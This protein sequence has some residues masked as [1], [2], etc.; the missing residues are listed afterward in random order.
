MIL[1]MKSVKEQ[2]GHNVRRYRDRIGLGQFELA[3]AVGMSQTAIGLL[4]RGKVWPE[5][6]NL[7]RIAEVCQVP[8]AAFFEVG[9]VEIKPTPEEALKVL[10]DALIKRS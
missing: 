6:D 2:L 7:V 1:L 9:R 8:V 3:E 4:E 10:S 5:Y